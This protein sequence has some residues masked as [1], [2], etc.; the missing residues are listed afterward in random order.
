MGLED[1][2]FAQSQWNFVRAWTKA[3]LI[4]SACF[5]QWISVTNSLGIY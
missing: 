3:Y 5:I 1:K 4:A 2:E